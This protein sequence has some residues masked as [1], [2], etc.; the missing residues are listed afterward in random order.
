VLGQIVKEKARI[1]QLQR[2]LQPESIAIKVSELDE[3]V[4]TLVL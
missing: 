3:R 2:H 4:G 1:Y